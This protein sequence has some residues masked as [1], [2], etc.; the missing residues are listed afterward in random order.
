M[1]ENEIS[2]TKLA[3]TKS[4]KQSK[5]TSFQ[6]ELEQTIAG[7]KGRGLLTDEGEKEHAI[8]EDDEELLAMFDKTIKRKGRASRRINKRDKLS[9]FAFNFE[10]S[11]DE[12]DKEKE[13]KVAE[14]KRSSFLKRDRKVEEHV[15]DQVDSVM[16]PHV[17][18]QGHVE[19]SKLTNREGHR[20]P[21]SHDRQVSFATSPSLTGNEE[22]R[23]TPV[24]MP[25]NRAAT[26]RSSAEGYSDDFSSEMTKSSR[27]P[28]PARTLS[29]TS[30]VSAS[31]Q[32]RSLSP[33]ETPAPTPALRHS[34]RQEMRREISGDISLRPPSPD[35]NPTDNGALPS[36][37]DSKTLTDG[38]QS[39]G[40]RA[41]SESLVTF[42]PEEPV[43]YVQTPYKPESHRSTAK[44]STIDPQSTEGQLFDNTLA[45][46]S[47]ENYSGGKGTGGGMHSETID[48]QF[49]NLSHTSQT[50]SSLNR[51]YVKSQRGRSPR[52]ISAKSR[53]LG[54]L[55]VLDSR[56]QLNV[57]LS[58][59]CPD[60]IRASIYQEWLKRK[61]ASIKEQK[62]IEERLK[63]E[64]EIKEQ[65]EKEDKKMEVESTFQ[66]WSK[67]KKK[68]IAEQQ[69]KKIE[70]DRE[71]Q[72]ADKAKEEHNEDAKKAAFERWKE[73][74]DKHIL[75]ECLKEKSVEREKQHKEKEKMD[76]K[77]EE[78]EKLYETWK[79]QKDKELKD[80]K[81]ELKQAKKRDAEERA[82]KECKERQ[83]QD[84]YEHW[85][86]KKES[87]QKLDR[88]LRKSRSLYQEE[89]PPWSP[90]NR[91]VPHG[92]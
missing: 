43:K 51:T 20:R 54:T 32:R 69:K 14:G 17:T 44:N 6:D 86:D 53:Y 1:P 92:K 50:A 12:E 85:M 49:E 74:K 10:L 40:K 9:S 11:D 59:E 26:G 25:R 5:R 66:A 41:S 72:K 23:S 4:P 56:S 57:S 61:T 19:D 58:P 28:S 33:S 46:I 71:K 55:K 7:W 78:A 29:S 65:K 52:P 88:R 2:S 18:S 80:K 3:H 39:M 91:T 27:S 24:P 90:P 8:D 89:V 13:K 82:I 81:K 36:G 22:G 79:K 64:K 15:D 67:Q 45:E 73:D 68:S 77:K 70:E 47:Q 84:E 16:E 83:A 35:P 38:P 21:R 87:Q 63:R 37:R 76:Q 42:I 31:T 60:T 30:R 75:K 34:A 48:D 62:E